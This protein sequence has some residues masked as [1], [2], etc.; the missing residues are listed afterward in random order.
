MEP[1]FFVIVLIVS[2]VLHEI[3][4]GYMALWLGDPTAKNAGRLTLNPIPH[5]DPVGSIALPLILSLLPGG[6][7]FGWAK[8]VPY[9]PYNL[10]AGKYGPAY[11]AAAGPLTNF[12]VALVFSLILNNH[13]WFGLGITALPLLNTIIYLNLAL[14]WFNLIPVPPLDGSKILF[15][16][17]PYKWRRVQEV[18]EGGQLGLLILVVFASSFIIS[19]L[20]NITH[21]LLTGF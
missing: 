11:V 8:P 17:L 19:P 20:I 7:V 2:V 12:I 4:H 21:S 9:N 1:I 14:M 16:F 15:A 3:A 10:K 6:V 13:S 18:L 5:I